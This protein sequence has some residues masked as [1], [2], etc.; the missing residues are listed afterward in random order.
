M[1]NKVNSYEELYYYRFYTLK[2]KI[3]SLKKYDVLSYIN[4][5]ELQLHDS[6]ENISKHR[7]WIVLPKILGIDSKLTILEDLIETNDQFLE[8]EII[9]L[10]ESDY[11]YIN[12]EMF[13]YRLTERTPNSII[14]Y[15]E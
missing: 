3:E 1:E 5:L 4:D 7:F 15:V 9:K 2:M 13:G 11:R 12:K 14:F 6:L 8:N 10:A